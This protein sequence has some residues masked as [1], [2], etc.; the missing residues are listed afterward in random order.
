MIQTL[1]MSK[2]GFFNELLSFEATMAP[3]LD[4]VK[5]KIQNLSGLL[6]LHAVAPNWRGSEKKSKTFRNDSFQS[7][8][9]LNST[10][11][12]SIRHSPSTESISSRSSLKSY[13]PQQQQQQ[14]QQQQQQHQKPQ[15]PHTPY[16]FVKYV[17]K[18]KNS[19]AQVKDTI[20]NTI[21]LSKLNKFSASTYDEIRDFLYQILGSSNDT[22]DSEEFVKE[23]MNLVF[24][25]HA[26]VSG[27]IS[28]LCISFWCFR[29]VM[30]LL[31]GE[32]CQGNSCSKTFDKLILPGDALKSNRR[33]VNFA[34]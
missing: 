10:L 11:R 28:C 5:L 23:F 15:Q 8:P 4:S 19:E 21:I 2:K 32:V 29:C 33:G 1:G 16:S 18:Y 9:S 3:P 24:C 22:N 13:S 30:K 14:H 20:L 7:L 25:S 12:P 27:A 17:S 31:E 6:D 26:G 34:W